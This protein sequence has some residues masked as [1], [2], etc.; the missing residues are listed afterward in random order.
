MHERRH[1]QQAVDGLRRHEV[2]CQEEVGECNYYRIMTY[3]KPI[4]GGISILVVGGLVGDNVSEM[5]T[6]VNNKMYPK[7]IFL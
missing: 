2:Q 3:K 5:D 1:M 6:N 7:W 4:H